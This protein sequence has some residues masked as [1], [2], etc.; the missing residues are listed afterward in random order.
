MKTDIKIDNVRFFS[1]GPRDVKRGLL[2]WISFVM[3]DKVHVD[4]LCLRKTLMGQLRISFPCRQDKSG[5]QHFY[6]RPLDNVAR[7][8][9]ERLVFRALGIREKTA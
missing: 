7:L 1:A 9:I 4:G 3:N 6:F 8:E 5:R 2:G